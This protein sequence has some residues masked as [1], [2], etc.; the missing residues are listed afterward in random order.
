MQPYGRRLYYGWVVLAAI[1]GLNFANSATAIG[2]L[3]VF[4][5][6]LSHDFGWTR[7]QI[8]AV[9][10]LGAILGALL[11]P[12]TGRLT[13][14]WGARLPLTL[15]AL[16]IV[17]A[18]MRLATMQSLLDFTLAFGLARL[19]D[20][21]LVQPSSPPALAKWFRR[22]RSRAIAG[23]FFTA[24]AGGVIMP[25]VVQLVIQTWHWRT[26]WL[27]LSGG[28]V[29]L[30]LIPCAW[31]VRRQ[32]DDLNLPI[33]GIPLPQHESTATGPQVAVT[34]DETSWQLSA[35]L[36]TPTLWCLL[37]SVLVFGMVS[38]GVG[39]HLVPALVQ[40]GLAPTAAV[41]A[42]SLG[43]FASG[44]GNL[45][46]GFAAERLPVS[47]LMV[48]VY[49]LRSASLVLLVVVH[50]LPGAYLF[51]VLQGFAEGG[52]GT[53]TAVLLAEYY[54]S[55]HLGS[56]YGM[57]RAVQVTGFALG[58]LIAGHIFDVTNSYQGAFVTFLG[59]SLIGTVAIA[60]ARAPRQ[61]GG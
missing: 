13:D 47:I 18:T 19:A 9:T 57:L 43:F 61:P 22:Y 34:H 44:A 24:A 20:Q 41:G 27:V 48:V 16:C 7:T 56:I 28:M 29:V 32:P 3:T 21:G 53:L 50:T 45:V 25:M 60:M 38:T 1:C 54:G 51:A 11:S 6:P 33:D 35:A 8:A 55:Q 46:W 40:Y 42:V 49:T 26:A 4:I 2:V 15:G 39:L 59:L 52:R 37:G 23:L 14:K 36:A 5:L 30:G 12:L 58:P 17:L 31:L 10:S